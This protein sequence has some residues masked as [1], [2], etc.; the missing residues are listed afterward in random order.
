MEYYKKESS[1]VLESLQSNSGGLNNAQA[2]KRL[3][4]YGPNKLDTEVKVEKWKIF[5]EQFK[6]FI[7]YI[8]LIAVVLSLLFKEFT[9]A[10]LILIILFVNAFIGYKQEISAAKS[11]S[12]LKKLSV[13]KAKVFRNKELTLLSSEELVPGDCILL[14]AGDKVPA[15][16]RI[17]QC[18]NLSIEEAALTG[19]SL[20]VQKTS[21][22][23]KK[24][25]QI[26]EQHNML[27]S[28]TN[29]T[30]GTA[31]AVVVSTGMK[32]EIG[33]ITKLIKEAED[34]QTPLQKRLDSFGKKLSYAV[35]VVCL[36]IFAAILFSDKMAG[37]EMSLLQATGA[38][39]A[40]AVALAVAA[41]PEGLPAVVTIAL[42]VGVKRL[43]HKSLSSQ[44][45][46]RRN[47][48]FLRCHLHRQNRN[49]NTK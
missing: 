12:A 5:L 22:T 15:D 47:S 49:T 35:I 9:D 16:C 37:G 1:E 20:P 44:T 18:S 17:L 28:S 25:A 27:F 43:L 39:L 23:L 7:I 11:L 34:E 2:E 48:R 3:Q 30:N 40:V 38:A 26:A 6:S 32:T 41:V 14:E 8:L 24:D 4:E 13:V 10:I 33:K 29:V 21:E 36:F 46:L 42:S 45:L 31:K 19:E